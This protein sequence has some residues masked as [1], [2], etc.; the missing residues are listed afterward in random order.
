MLILIGLTVIA[1]GCDSGPKSAR[2]FSLPDG[3]VAIGQK[4]FLE[5][6]CNACHEVSGLDLPDTGETKELSVMLGGTVSRLKTYGEWVTCTIHPA[7]RL[8][9]GYPSDEIQIE[10]R[11]RMLN[12]NDAMTVSELIDLVSF[13]QS[14]YELR[15]YDMTNYPMY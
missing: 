11:S 4:T 6:R 15:E 3:D 10:G 14:H 7:H 5:M 9:T 8:A 1:A 12:Y 13:L 2:G